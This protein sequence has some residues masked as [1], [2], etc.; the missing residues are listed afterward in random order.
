MGHGREFAKEWG[1][2]NRA[3]GKDEVMSTV[4]GLATSH[5]RTQTNLPGKLAQG[6]V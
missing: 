5:L 1:D 6:Q 4:D 2:D 3:Q